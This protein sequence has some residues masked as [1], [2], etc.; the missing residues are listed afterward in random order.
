[1]RKVLVSERLDENAARWLAERASVVFVPVGDRDRLLAELATADAL[2]IRTYTQVDGELL[3][4]APALR[5]VG[6]C[7]VGL[8]NVDLGAC[9]RRGIRVVYTPDANTEAVVQYVFALVLDAVRPRRDL[10]AGA[11]PDEFHERR[12]TDVGRELGE[13]TL[14]ILGM[15][16]IGRRVAE[17]AR[18]FRMPLVWNDLLSAEELG[19]AA[20]G[21]VPKEEL[22]PLSDVLTVHVDG[23]AE[24]RR[25]ID[26]TVLE[27][28]K[29][30]C[31]LINAARGL[32][33]DADALAAWADRVRPSGGRAILD[34]HDPEPPS[35]D[36]ALWNR[37]NVRLLPHLASR[38][39]RALANMS[40]VVRDVVRV[41]D[42][43]T[44]EYAAV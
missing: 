27:R 33:V 38:T 11:T 28:L 44:P 12:T 17:V 36:Y 19:I 24:N 6:R 16:R 8:E 31:L 3:D 29:P 32:I 22:W 2:V 20:E 39:D 30:D 26:G 14:G 5:V 13:L 42:G 10:L 25:L 1:M 18:G 9:R 15:G 43:K 41:L 37:P 23:R 4:R 7:G 35:A 40:G 21:A 34:V